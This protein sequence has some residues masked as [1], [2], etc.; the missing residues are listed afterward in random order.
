MN[1]QTCFCPFI[2]LDN[3]SDSHK[4]APRWNNVEVRIAK[5]MTRYKENKPKFK[6]QHVNKTANQNSGTARLYIEFN[7]IHSDHVVRLDGGIASALGYRRT[8]YKT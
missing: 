5:A 6:K 1:T 4:N 7:P 8:V 2:G 3:F